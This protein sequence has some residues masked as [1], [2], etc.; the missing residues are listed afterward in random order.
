MKYKYKLVKLDSLSGNK[1]SVYSVYD[2]EREKTLFQIFLEENKN[3]FISEIKNLWARL[4]VIG[5]KEGARHGFFKHNEGKPGDGV[6]ALYDE[7][8][9]NLRLYCVRYGTLIVLLGGGGIKPKEIRAFQEDPKLTSEN[10]IL[11]EISLQIT[12]K[13]KSKELKFS[14]NLLDFEGDL[15]FYENDNDE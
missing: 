5:K 15:N 4:V 1:A 8:E 3:S 14:A 11:R 7:P 10:Y 12:D 6:C 2:Y 9:K 13:L